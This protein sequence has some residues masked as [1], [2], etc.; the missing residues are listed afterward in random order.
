MQGPVRPE[1]DPPLCQPCADQGGAGLFDYDP[2]LPGQ[3]AIGDLLTVGKGEDALPRRSAKTGMPGMPRPLPSPKGPTRA[4][5]DLHNLT[6]APF[7]VWCPYC[8]SGK[9]H[10]HHHL[11]RGNSST[12]PMLPAD[13][14]YYGEDD[15]VTILVMHVKPYGVMFACVADA[16]GPTP[17]MGAYSC[18]MDKDVWPCPISLSL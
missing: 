15:L 2:V 14:A 1:N 7:A 18:R 6:H 9:R 17:N 12:L 11:R 8:V 3:E 5:R 13:Y 16:K 10:N 4:E